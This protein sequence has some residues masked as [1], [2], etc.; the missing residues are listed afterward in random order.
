MASR[1]GAQPAG[2]IKPACG[3]AGGM[4]SSHIAYAGIGSASQE[5]IS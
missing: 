1:A 4:A 3:L 5:G 2:R